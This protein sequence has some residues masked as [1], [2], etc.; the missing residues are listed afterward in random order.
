MAMITRFST[1]S[2]AAAFATRLHG[3]GR[4]AEI[5][6]LNASHLWGPYP[7]WGIPVIH[8]EPEAADLDG[9]PED[10]RSWRWARILILGVPLLCGLLVVAGYAALIAEPLRGRLGHVPE[11]AL[12][13][14]LTALVAVFFARSLR[15]TAASEDD[16]DSIAQIHWLSEPVNRACGVVLTIAVVAV[17]ALGAFGILGLLVTMVSVPLFGLSVLLGLVA[18]AG[19]AALGHFIVRAHRDPQ[20]DLHSA[21]V[22]CCHGVIW[23]LLMALVM[24]L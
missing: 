15:S 21:V 13:A 11:L 8:S 4:F 1:L 16:P 6:H 18:L 20:P 5:I 2:D 9:L 17:A 14:F 7:D 19:T 10:G 22:V 24:V 12:I 3:E 23:Y